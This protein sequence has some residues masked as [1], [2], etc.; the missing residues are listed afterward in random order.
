MLK[1]QEMGTKQSQVI[2]AWVEAINKNPK[3]KINFVFIFFIMFFAFYFN[4]YFDYYI[5]KKSK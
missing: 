3:I 2:P 5:F 4:E 1:F